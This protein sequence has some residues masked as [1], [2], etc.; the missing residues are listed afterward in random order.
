MLH[1]SFTGECTKCVGKERNQNI[2]LASKTPHKKERAGL[3]QFPTDCS[4]S[5]GRSN[6]KCSFPWSH[7]CSRC[8]SLR[9]VSNVLWPPVTPEP[10]VRLAEKTLHHTSLLERL[11]FTCPL[12]CTLEVLWVLQNNMFPVCS[13][14]ICLNDSTGLYP[15]YHDKLVSCLAHIQEAGCWK[16][17]STFL[18][19]ITIIWPI[20]SWL[21]LTKVNA[22]EET[23]LQM[24]YKNKNVLLIINFNLQIVQLKHV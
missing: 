6:S 17:E 14:L 1:I 4:S 11:L 3:S 9:L 20:T 8:Y 12:V 13:K 5:G 2:Y 21:H 24:T 16:G 7:H 22:R 19:F 10:T 15:A 18:F 23:K